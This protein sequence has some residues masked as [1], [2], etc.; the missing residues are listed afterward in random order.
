MSVS[1]RLPL[2]LALVAAGRTSTATI[3]ARAYTLAADVSP[4]VDTGAV[5]AC[6]YSPLGL[7]PWGTVPLGVNAFS[8]GGGVASGFATG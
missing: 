3:R 1:Y 5:L 7:W 8:Y 6:G 2:L 4:A